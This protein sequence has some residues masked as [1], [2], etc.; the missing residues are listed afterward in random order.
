[1]TTPDLEA[2][3]ERYRAERDKRLRPDGLDQYVHL[4]GDL[5]RLAQDP[6]IE[7]PL[8]RDAMETDVD[9]VIVGAGLGALMMAVNLRRLGL[10]QVAMVDRAGDVGGTWYWNRYP[11][12]Q[13]DT[14]SYVYLPFLEETGYVP[15]E[16][17][18]H[19]PE[20]LE[21][22]RRIARHFDLYKDAVFQTEVTEATWDEELRRWEVRTD[23][24]D[25]LNARYLVICP[26]RLQSPK[27]PGIPGIERFRGRA[28]HTSRWDRD[29]AGADLDRL[30]GQ[31]V[32]IIGTGATGLQC[33]PRLA[34][35]AEQLYVFQR[36][37]SAVWVRGNRPTPPGWA[38]Q[39]EPGWQRRRMWNFTAVSSGY[40]PPEGEEDMV[41]DGWT[42]IASWLTSAPDEDPEVTD[43]RVMERIRAR[44]DELVEDPEAAKAL[45][46]YYRYGCKRPTFHDEFLPTFNR[47]NVQLVDTEGAGPE[48]ITEHAVVVDGKHY[49]VDA[50][51]FAT[52]F[53]LGMG[54][55][56]GTGLTIRG[57]RGELLSEKWSEGL[58]TY[59]GL[60]S[61]GFPNCFFLGFTQTAFSVSYTHMALEQTEH[62]AHVVAEAERRDG[63]VEATAEAETAW[64]ETIKA[65]RTPQMRQLQWECT[66]GANNNEGN[67]DDPNTLGAGRYLPAGNHFFELLHEWRA[68]GSY[69]GVVF[70]PRTSTEE[71][72]AFLAREMSPACPAQ[73]WPS[74]H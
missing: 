4:E 13:C 48:A 25:V 10:D 16:K 72:G 63:F 47:A 55:L 1:M 6:W 28:W 49:E 41:Q 34:A 60:Y 53:D 35:V 70:D 8:V 65:G 74:A 46:A 12:A 11:G 37:P 71:G 64:V 58:R 18:A 7:E 15:T 32:G 31:R 38:E 50:L 17:Y 3:R 9:V 59:H 69:D 68:E 52:G 29:F 27:L 42:E 20:I 43:L 33:I 5:A 54:F 21:H 39:L 44:V 51:V 22:C 56:Y 67:P 36:T 57:R 24:G 40:P 14:E 23:R 30:A 61:H 45:K 19:Q 73:V 62:V 26:G 66:P 2:V